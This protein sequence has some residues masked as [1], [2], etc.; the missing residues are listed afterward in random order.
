M[1]SDGARRV[2]DV[3]AD[4]RFDI[5]VENAGMVGELI[6][7][8]LRDPGSRQKRSIGDH[9]IFRI[10]LTKLSFTQRHPPETGGFPC[11]IVS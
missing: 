8:N 3:K 6:F 10:I 5:F 4:H 1:S 9:L 7:G 2:L 11:K